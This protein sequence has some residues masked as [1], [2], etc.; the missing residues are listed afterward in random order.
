[1][2][3]G[4][5]STT[6]RVYKVALNKFMAWFQAPQPGFTKARVSGDG[7]PG[8]SAPCLTGY[9]HAEKEAP[10]YKVIYD[11]GSLS[12]QKAGTGMKLFVDPKQI[13]LV[14]DKAEVIAITPATRMRLK[15]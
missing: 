2:D 3:S 4:Y 6:K 13:R 15:N 14:R 10:S 9:L 5:S 12:G 8:P 1:M 7:I 11:G